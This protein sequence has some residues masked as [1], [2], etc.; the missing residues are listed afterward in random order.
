MTGEVLRIL[1]LILQLAF[2]GILYLILLA[3]VRSL[4]RDLRS[5]ERA[6]LANQAGIGRLNVIESP[7]DEPPAGR[8]G[9]SS[10]RPTTSASSTSIA[11]PAP[12]DTAARAAATADENASTTGARGRASRG[13]AQRPPCN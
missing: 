12:P 3:F 2:L 7:D 1:L 5:A 9:G 6:Q 8:N 4:L 10:P 13:F 11:S